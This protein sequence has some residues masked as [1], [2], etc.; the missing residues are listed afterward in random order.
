MNASLGELLR[1]G[2]PILGLLGGL[3]LWAWY[4]VV[5]HH[6]GIGRE[7]RGGCRWLSGCL[8]AWRRRDLAAALDAIPEA[9]TALARLLVALEQMP[10]VT[11]ADRER[12]FSAEDRRLRGGLPLIAVLATAAPLLGLLGTLLGLISAFDALTH[13]ERDARGLAGGIGTAL[14]TTQAGLVVGIPLLV[15]HAVQDG[16]AR[17][18][19]EVLEAVWSEGTRRGPRP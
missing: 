15:A 18:A 19:L 17:R 16:R 5:R 14:L 10:R 12:W 8:A 3:A 11:A 6:Q 4:L 2:G 13:S 1:E 9:G 7:A